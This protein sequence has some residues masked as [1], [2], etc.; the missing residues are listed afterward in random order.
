[1]NKIAMTKAQALAKLAEQRKKASDRVAKF[2][3]KHVSVTVTV[4]DEASAEMVR[5]YAKRLRMGTADVVQE[6]DHDQLQRSAPG[7][8]V[9]IEVNELRKT[10][11]AVKKLPM[12]SLNQDDTLALAVLEKRIK[13]GAEEGYS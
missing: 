8:G 5:L 3:A 9:Q 6:R 1:M 11:R 12:L 2:R 7:P 4:P 10:I 13:A